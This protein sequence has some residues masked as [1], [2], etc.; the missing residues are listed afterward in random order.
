LQILKYQSIKITEFKHS[1]LINMHTK[2]ITFFLLLLVSF[3][4]CFS[5]F[6]DSKINKD[7]NKVLE[8]DE[9]DEESDFFDDDE[10]ETFFQ[11]KGFDHKESDLADELLRSIRS[12]LDSMGKT[13]HESTFEDENGQNTK[14]HCLCHE[15]KT[16]KAY[17]CDII[18]MIHGKQE[19]F[20]HSSSMTVGP[21]QEVPTWEKVVEQMQLV[22]TARQILSEKL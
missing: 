14:I 10:W 12:L 22:R 21:F 9:K 18:Q 7:N 1:K 5:L 17:V 19:T 4:F 16:T 2:N 15:D 13:I 11:D 20:K 8:D 3:S 6:S